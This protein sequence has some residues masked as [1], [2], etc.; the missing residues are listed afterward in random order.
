MTDL[1]LL[2]ALL[3]EAEYYI[4]GWVNTQNGEFQFNYLWINLSDFDSQDI[5]ERIEGLTFINGIAYKVIERNEQSNQ[6]LLICANFYIVAIV[7]I[8]LCNVKQV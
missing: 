3:D 6:L 5:I 8:V 1:I 7:N 4:R 2:D